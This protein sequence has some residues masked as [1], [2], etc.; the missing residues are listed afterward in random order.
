[1]Q[2]RS[3][4]AVWDEDWGVGVWV[5]DTEVYDKQTCLL[6]RSFEIPRK[7]VV[8]SAVL[9]I[10]VDNGYTLMLNG[11]NIGTGSDWRSITEY[12]ITRL[13][14]P[15]RH[16]LAIEAFNDNRE[17]GLLFGLRI[18]L[19]DG[20][21]IDIPSDTG[22]R[23]V[24][25]GERGWT[26]RREAQPHWEHVVEVSDLLPRPGFWHKRTPTMVVR[27]PKLE[28]LNVVYWKSLWFQASLVGVLGISLLVSLQLM[29][30][31]AVQSKARKMID[32]ERARIAR[33]IHDELG[34]RLT[35]LALEGEVVQ[36]ELPEQS[37]VRP[38]LEALCEKA[39]A[40]SGAMDELVWVV[41]SRR[42]T[43]QDFATYACKHA[44]RFLEATPIRC[45]LDVDP[46][47]P[48]LAL[49]LPVR[50]NLLLGVKEALNNAAKHS[51]ADE[52]F[53][54]IHV[55]GQVLQVVVEDNGGGFDLERVDSTRNGLTNMVERMSE[56][57]GRCRIESREGAG[58]RV[59]FQI[60][61][62]RAARH[63][64]SPL[65]MPAAGTSLMTDDPRDP[66]TTR[67][68]IFTR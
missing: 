54:R 37:A 8:A 27:V 38:R 13:L 39:R 5:W 22:W 25:E 43:L 68:G 63:S 3:R 14:G 44:Q 32:R 17:A 65:L 34:A 16:V 9:R 24:P 33:D 45:R 67:G 52:L 30:R 42:D 36:T 20:R 53:L 21:V 56:I 10:S 61:L 4:D 64:F 19:T 1:M 66:A 11:R 59:E 15:G 49:D 28:P 62:R 48:E 6:W 29:G 41:N 7:A 58:C 12:D 23:V 57:G 60:S 2:E 31:L 51:G 47:L 35:E 18:A 26:T 55:R 46:D 50:R 40:A